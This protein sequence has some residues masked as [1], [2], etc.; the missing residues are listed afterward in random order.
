MTNNLQ[1]QIKFVAKF[2]LSPSLAPSLTLSVSTHKLHSDSLSHYQFT[3]GRMRNS[4]AMSVSKIDFLFIF[5][6]VLIHVIFT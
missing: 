5:T 1:F 4:C 3:R 2:N 6:D